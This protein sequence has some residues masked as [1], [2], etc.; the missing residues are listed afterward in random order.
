LTRDRGAACDERFSRDHFIFPDVAE[1]SAA[2]FESATG[3]PA[4]Q[5][6]AALTEAES[7]IAR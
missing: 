4:Q 3:D 6:C 7:G 5:R 2:G 1:S